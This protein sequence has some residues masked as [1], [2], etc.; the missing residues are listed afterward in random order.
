MANLSQP[1]SVNQI[2][3]TV[4]KNDDIVRKKKKGTVTKN[5]VHEIALFGAFPGEETAEIML[6]DI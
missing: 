5:R 4:L 1:A 2:W 6:K 3:K